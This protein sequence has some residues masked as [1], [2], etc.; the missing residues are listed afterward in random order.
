MRSSGPGVRL[1]PL[2]STSILFTCGLSPIN[3]YF[4]EL[5]LDF[6]HVSAPSFVLLFFLRGT[7]S[8]SFL[9]RAHASIVILIHRFGLQHV[10][11][12]SVPAA[13]RV[14]ADRMTVPLGGFYS[15]RWI[16]FIDAW[17]FF[18]IASVSQCRTSCM[19]PRDHRRRHEGGDALI[20]DPGLCFSLC[21]LPRFW[22]ALAVVC[23]RRCRLTS[24]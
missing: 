19:G 11:H 2:L 15:P 12:R 1:S 3:F 18:S 24:S 17:E 6:C 4:F 10:L 5:E 21:S 7:P 20:A 22:G 23:I 9:S 16:Y 8:M 14:K 13:M